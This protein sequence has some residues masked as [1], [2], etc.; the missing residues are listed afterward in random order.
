MGHPLTRPVL[1]RFHDCCKELFLTPKIYSNSLG[2]SKYSN[3]GFRERKPVG[4][5]GT[6]KKS[7][8]KSA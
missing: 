3:I 4:T 7:N 8:D 2:R 5:F 6:E 1:N